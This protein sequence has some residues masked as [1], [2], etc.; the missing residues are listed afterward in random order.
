MTQATGPDP[1]PTIDGIMLARRHLHDYLG[2]R[3]L[4]ANV[5]DA[6]AV[7]SITAVNM[8]L[9]REP[10]IDIPDCVSQVIGEWILAVQDDL[11]DSLLNG[12]TWKS[13]LPEVIGTSRE[14]GHEA[15][16]LELLT[17]WLWERVLPRAQPVADE[18]G[19]GDLWRDFI[20]CRD[21]ATADAVWDDVLPRYTRVE[22][23]AE[24]SMVFDLKELVMHAGFVVQGGEADLT[25]NNIGLCCGL[26]W[27]LLER[28]PE[29]ASFW[30][31]VDPAGL[32]VRL[33]D[34][35]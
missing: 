10:T 19:A 4:R 23:D 11:P 24:R 1:G 22:T 28:R 5:M 7:C 30:T 32:L 26:V 3:T 6:W 12:Y 34:Q 15:L 17:A 21:R 29:A 20:R 14:P 2:R 18:L 13:A 8:A 16:K 9:G 31:D 35:G 27:G 33:T 25:A